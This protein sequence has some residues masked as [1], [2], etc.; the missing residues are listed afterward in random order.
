MVERLTAQQ[1][2]VAAQQ[3]HETNPSVGMVESLVDEK[4]GIRYQPQPEDGAAQQPTNMVESLTAQQ[5]GVIAQP[6]HET[7]KMVERLTAQ[8]SG[9]AAKQLHETNPSVGMVESLTAQQSKMDHH[10]D[11]LQAGAAQQPTK[12]KK[13]RKSKKKRKTK[14]KDMPNVDEVDIAATNANHEHKSC[15]GLEQ[16]KLNSGLPVTGTSKEQHRKE[17][18]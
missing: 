4:S 3:S 15:Q 8:Q 7:N 14:M 9:V 10:E 17:N 12:V 16:P 18:K 1:S 6:S 11:D 13:K 2:G 5:S